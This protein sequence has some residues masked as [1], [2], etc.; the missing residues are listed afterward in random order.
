MNNKKWPI[1]V[2]AAALAAV[3]AI[4]VFALLRINNLSGEATGLRSRNAKL[5]Q[6]LAEIDGGVDMIGQV[7]S[8]KARAEEAE[9][10]L[11]EKDAAL[12]ES[13]Q[14]ARQLSDENTS[15]Q[16]ELDRLNS[17]LNPETDVAEADDVE[18]QLMRARGE[19]E[20]RLAEYRDAERALVERVGPTL[21][22]HVIVAREQEEEAGE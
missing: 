18:T 8:A 1:W 16:A 13:Q 20:R 21:T 12:S 17:I 9:S 14:Q 7:T 11:A 10:A 6:E 3:T 5:S 2:M 4:L 19:L 22:H 15:L